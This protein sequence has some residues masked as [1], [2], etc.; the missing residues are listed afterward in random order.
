MSSRTTR[1]QPESRGAL[2]SKSLPSGLI[3]HHRNLKHGLSLESLKTNGPD[4]GE[5]L[6]DRSMYDGCGVRMG[7][8]PKK[9]RMNDNP[10][11]GPT[12]SVGRPRGVPSNFPH[13]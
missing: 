4:C 7:C 12:I 9:L 10:T 6:T 2:S 13:H 5:K 8:I 1:S 3:F 11:S